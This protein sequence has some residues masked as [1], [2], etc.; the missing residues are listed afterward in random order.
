[1]L[2]KYT[3]YIWKT[4]LTS[5]RLCYKYSLSYNQFLILTFVKVIVVIL[6][7]KTICNVGIE[8]L[9]EVLLFPEP[10]PSCDTDCGISL[11]SNA[12]SSGIASRFTVVL[13]CRL[14]PRAPTAKVTA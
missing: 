9:R 6:K 10:Q 4:D 13:G 11:W 14:A 8:I 3:R 7:F 12:Q 5:Y 1:M 2:R